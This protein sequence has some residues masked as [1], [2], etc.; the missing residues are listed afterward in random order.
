M[1]NTSFLPNNTH[2]V[3]Q[4]V[5][6]MEQQLQQ[7]KRQQQ[8]QQGA[9]RENSAPHNSPWVRESLPP[10][11]SPM[12]HSTPESESEPRWRRQAPEQSHGQGH[13]QPL[14]DMR[15]PIP[16]NWRNNDHHPT[17]QVA[18]IPDGAG[19]RSRGR[20]PRMSFERNQ[21]EYEQHSHSSQV[22]GVSPPSPMFAQHFDQQYRQQH[23]RILGGQDVSIGREFHQTPQHPNWILQ[24][25][26]YASNRRYSHYEPHQPNT[27][28]NN[29]R[30][31]QRQTHQQARRNPGPG[32]SSS[33]SSHHTNAPL[34]GETPACCSPK[35]SP[36][37]KDSQEDLCVVCMENPR[38]ASIIHGDSGHIVCCLDCA[39]I[40]K[41][42]GNSCPVCRAAIDL[43]VKNYY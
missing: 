20:Q 26:P 25:N 15:S 32:V 41:A 8:Q 24:S 13:T 21:R 43:V 33:S 3:R 23:T 5:Q 29:S 6:R 38:N 18:W 37:G 28:S 19:A 16:T 27:T 2:T 35:P 30:V 17:G 14:S 36:H 10:P 22:Q 4:Q 7:Q 34:A 12:I 40:L 1:Q 9:S 31:L 11:P 39:N 42:K